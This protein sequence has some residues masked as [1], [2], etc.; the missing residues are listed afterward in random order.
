M[1][2]RE[3]RKIDLSYR[4]LGYYLLL[5]LLKT[6]SDIAW[7]TLL[8]SASTLGEIPSYCRKSNNDSS[9]EHKTTKLNKTNKMK[10]ESIFREKDR[11]I[12]VRRSRNPLRSV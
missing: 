4:Q 7:N 6:I 3:N 11:D 1:V 8:N 12:F 2:I 9:H 10:Q 5:D